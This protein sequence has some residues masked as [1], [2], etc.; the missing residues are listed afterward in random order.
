MTQT[1]LVNPGEG[2]D[3]LFRSFVKSTSIRIDEGEESIALIQ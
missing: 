2:Y 3:P 1:D